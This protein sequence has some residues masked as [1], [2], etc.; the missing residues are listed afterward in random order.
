VAGG[1]LVVG[2]RAASGGVIRALDAATGD[3]L[4]EPRPLGR[5]V[6][7]PAVV[8]DRGYVAVGDR[9]T[10]SVVSVDLETGETLW[11]DAVGWNA[12]AATVGGETLVVT[13]HVQTGG[14]RIGGRIRAYNR[15]NGEVR[16]TRDL[17]APGPDGLALVGERVLVTVGASLYELR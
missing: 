10:G 5:D 9:E 6:S 2:S 13:G 1:R 7:T 14:E 15:T 11:R 8:D 17:P 3:P 16:W 12:A 4:W